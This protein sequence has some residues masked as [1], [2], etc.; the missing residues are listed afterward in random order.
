M[1]KFK[2][3]LKIVWKNFWEC[4]VHSLTPGIMYFLAGAVLL[5]VLAKMEEDVDMSKLTT[6]AIVVGVIAVAYHGLLMWAHGGS[7]FE[8][9]VSGNMKR[10]SSNYGEELHISSHKI[11]KEYRPW[12]GFLSG[13]FTSVPLIIGAIVF[14]ANAEEISST[15]DTLGRGLGI[16]VIVFDLL[17]GWVLLPFQMSARLGANV[18]FY[19]LMLFALLQIAVSGGLYIAG[20]YSRRAKRIREQE[21]AA[22]AAAAEAEARNRPKKINYGGLPGTKPRKRK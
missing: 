10:R 13:F 12:K 16:A 4:F 5:Y 19:L 11:W 14:G 8:M 15:A 1:S 20:A 18:N 3:K 6:W 17:A 2:N 7:H 21:I 9:L 22:K